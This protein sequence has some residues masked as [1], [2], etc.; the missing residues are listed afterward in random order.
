MILTALTQLYRHRQAL[1]QTTEVLHISGSRPI[2]T[3]Q[4]Y[5][6]F[7]HVVKHKIATLSHGYGYTHTAL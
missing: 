2:I 6:Y 7:I 5:L 1:T 3:L 4:V